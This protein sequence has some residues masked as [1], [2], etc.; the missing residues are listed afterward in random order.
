MLLAAPLFFTISRADAQ[1]RKGKKGVKNE[2]SVKIPVT[3]DPRIAMNYFMEAEKYYMLE[4]YTKAQLL[5]LKTLELQPDNAAVQFKVAQV[6]T[7]TGDLDKALPYARQAV[8]LDPKNKFYYLLLAQIYTKKSDFNDAAAIYDKMI[9]TIP[10]T[11]DYL[12]QKDYN[13]AL[14]CYDKLENSFGINEQICLQK[15]E[16]YIKL[17]KLDDAIAEGKKLIDAYPDEPAYVLLQANTMLANDKAQDAINLLEP[18]I[19]SYPDNGRILLAMAEAYKGAGNE[20]KSKEYIEKAFNSPE[21]DLKTKLQYIAQQINRPVDSLNRQF[22][23]QLATKTVDMYPDNADS[24]AIYGDLLYQ[25][26]SVNAAKNMYLKSLDIDANNFQAWQN[27][28]N[29]ELNQSDWDD[30]IKHSEKAVEIFPNQSVLYF[31]LGSGYF[32]TKDYVNSVA[33]LEIGK[34][35]SSTNL[36]LTSL[37]NAQLGDAYYY[38]KDFKKSDS[39][40]EAVLK[41]DPNNDH[42]LNNYS[43]FLSLRKENLDQANKMSSKL[44]ELHPD[45]PTYLDTRAWVSR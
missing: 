29:I 21:L 5:F 9:N 25:V 12:Y 11:D 34:K 3:T 32:M 4:D 39:A 1:K 17:G 6:Y 30:V 23:F 19:V 15:K 37:F 40:Y 7:Q 31:F 10:G 38:L 45:D 13:N 35:F 44:I 28:I 16:I 36:S 2:N 43:Y 42:V 22:L 41:F 27:V 24:Y 26:D 33:N 14:K 8:T 20:M 18:K